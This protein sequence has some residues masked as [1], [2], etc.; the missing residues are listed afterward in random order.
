MDYEVLAG[1]LIAACPS[2]DG[3]RS[4]LWREAVQAGVRQLQ[5]SPDANGDTA[6]IIIR[7]VRYTYFEHMQQL[8][9][10]NVE[11]QM[12]DKS[13]QQLGKDCGAIATHVTTIVGAHHSP[14]EARREEEKSEPYH[15]PHERLR[16][17][18]SSYGILE[19]LERRMEEAGNHVRET[20]S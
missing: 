14:Q 11:S 17:L 13:V 8:L 2:N 10:S 6:Q 15:D 7:V 9:H 16:W 5:R 4:V 1:H 3:V 12:T 20:S 19:N 18:S